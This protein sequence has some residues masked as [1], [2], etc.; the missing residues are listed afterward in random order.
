MKT[1][2]K[3]KFKEEWW[4]YFLDKS[5]YMSKPTVF[6]NSLSKKETSLMRKL[7]LQVLQ[8]LA[9]RRTTRFGYRVYTKEGRILNENEMNFIYDNPPRDYENLEQWWNRVFKDEEIGM[10]I[11]Q[12]ERFNLQLSEMIAKKIKPLLKKTGIPTEGIIFTLFIGNYNSTPLGIHLDLPGKNVIHFH[13]GPGSKTIYTWD[14]TEKYVN[15][16]GQ[17]S[18]NNKDLESYLPLASKHSFKEGDLFCMP[19]DIYHVGIQEGLSIGIACWC[20][21][22][23][24]HDFM[25]QLINMLLNQYLKKDTD[26][27]VRNPNNNLKPDRK[28]LNDSSFLDTTL[29]EWFDFP[30]GYE[31]LT[32]NEVLKE[33]YKDLRYSLHSNAG[34]RTSP[35][36]LEKDYNFKLDTLVYLSSPY[37]IK[38]RESL[39]K[40]KLYI[41]IRGIMISLDNH[42]CIKD[43][44]DILNEEE[45]IAVKNLLNI[46]DL[47]W[48]KE[49]G[50]YILNL[51]YKHHGIK[52]A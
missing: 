16:A 35:F 21:N 44:I 9:K 15:L 32:F 13:L 31:S 10:I 49:V 33:I 34:Y 41:Y 24:K 27:Y 26:L 12:G 17:K 40:E 3:E 42:N 23:S 50:F 4:D 43:F 6:K 20:N 51:I 29:Q 30:N 52:I 5:N 46:L 19:E 1:S 38:Y 48:D 47:S 37:Q 22:R 7:I 14:D 11:N 8:E 28:P 45:V 2:V 25:E 39:D 18:Q 36:P